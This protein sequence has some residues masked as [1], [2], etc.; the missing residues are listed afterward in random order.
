MNKLKIILAALFISACEKSP[1]VQ[2][3]E[4]EYSMG[5]DGGIV[6]R[7]VV[8]DGNEYYTS[9]TT[10]GYWALCPKLPPKN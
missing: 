4:R 7:T 2:D 1:E 10:H 8:I 9:R 5:N 3:D 6:V